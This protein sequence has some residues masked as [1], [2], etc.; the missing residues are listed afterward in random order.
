MSSEDYDEHEAVFYSLLF[1]TSKDLRKIGIKD[2]PFVTIMT[3]M[4]GSCPNRNNQ[5]KFF[6]NDII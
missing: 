6:K 4:F 5:V 1:N 3:L 2:H